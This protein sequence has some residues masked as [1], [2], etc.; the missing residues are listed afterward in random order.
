MG[1]VVVRRKVSASADAVWDVM[2]DFGG[3]L[4]WNEGMESCT[5]DGEGVGAVRTIGMP[6]GFSLQER[7]E[8]HDPAARHY[9]YAIIGEPALPFQD[10]LSK[11][12]IEPAGDDAC[13]VDWR[14]SFSAA[15]E[16]TAVKIITGI[17]TGGLAA[18]GKHL[19]VDVSEID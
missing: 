16:G 1:E 2:S 9:A 8:A 7:L 13:V 3:L 18:L 6:G 17:Y 4:S 11:V 10:Y 15:D 19:G 5:V 12:N 14:S